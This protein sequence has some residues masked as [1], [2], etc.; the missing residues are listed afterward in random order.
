[1]I[2]TLISRLKHPHLPISDEIE[3]TGL[4]SSQAEE[5]PFIR[6]KTSYR[7][8]QRTLRLSQEKDKHLIKLSIK[9][10]HIRKL[11]EAHRHHHV[12]DDFLTASQRK[13]LKKK[14][15]R[16]LTHIQISSLYNR[17]W[18]EDIKHS[19]GLVKFFCGPCRK[20]N[21]E[22]L[23][24][25]FKRIS[26]N[27]QYI[28][29]TSEYTSGLRSIEMKRLDRALANFSKVKSCYRKSRFIENER[30]RTFAKEE[31]LYSQRHFKRMQN[32]PNLDCSL[33][34][35]LHELLNKKEVYPKI[36]RLWIYLHSFCQSREKFH[37][38]A[39]PNL[40]ELKFNGFDSCCLFDPSV[41]QSFQSLQ[42]LEKLDLQI[43]SQPP[44][45]HF[46]FEAFLELPQLSS[47][48]L[49]V[50]YLTESNWK[51]LTTFTQNQQ[52]LVSLKFNIAMLNHNTCHYPPN[53]FFEEF[54]ASL[55]NKPKLQYLFLQ[56]NYWPLQ[57]I[58]QGFTQLAGSTNLKSFSL[59]SSHRFFSSLELPQHPFQS[60]GEFLLKNKET[61]YELILDFPIS[62]RQGFDEEITQA[63]SQLYQL[64][65]FALRFSHFRGESEDMVE[66]PQIKEKKLWDPCL[67]S[68]L[69]TLEKL[70]DLAL[71]FKIIE[72]QSPENRKWLTR[73][74]QVLP[75]LKNLRRFQ[76][77]VPEKGLTQDEVDTINLTLENL[78]Y[79]NFLN[80]LEPKENCDASFHKI[81]AKV[82]TLRLRQAL[83]VNFSFY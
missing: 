56:S 26:Q 83:R 77:I 58:S 19:K 59:R 45:I 12:N 74:F 61:L 47:F 16:N 79:L 48:S 1:M 13:C 54:L 75:F 81:L 38:G 8:L 32:P 34:E 52:N 14:L 62:K 67:N 72:I 80:M 18:I 44:T 50:D 9:R 4:F 69:K 66:S 17:Y 70:E 2:Q 25:Y 64:K 36:T 23:I 15:F 60:L 31:F 46:L 28:E 27:L 57:T 20:C 40:K 10:I 82:K 29:F 65:N 30:N 43:F 39:F 37:F 73:S 53:S 21:P 33:S 11:I 51:T 68:L 6:P 55:S 41:V 49:S 42:S 78:N 71:D 3:V 24:R 63:I 35:T 5:I 7:Y 76:F 22:T